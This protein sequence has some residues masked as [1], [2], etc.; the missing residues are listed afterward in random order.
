MV[1]DPTPPSGGRYVILEH[2]YPRRHWDFLLEKGDVLRGWRLTEAPERGKS[3]AAE[4]SFDHR[5]MY[6]DYEGP[7]SGGRGQ[8]LRW[9]AG[10][11]SWTKDES[12]DIEVSL[13]GKRCH[14][15][16]KLHQDAAGVWQFL[17]EK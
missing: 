16:A 4:A 10:S 2:D 3:I 17:W 12:K 15:T 6:L 7:I 13:E 11:F 14:G 5:K 9:D 1:K 8:V